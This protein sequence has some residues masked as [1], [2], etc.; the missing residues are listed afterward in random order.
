VGVILSVVLRVPDSATSASDF[1][2]QDMYHK[3][4]LSM[5]AFAFGSFKAGNLYASLV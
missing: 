3:T 5:R 1:H 4:K 2:D